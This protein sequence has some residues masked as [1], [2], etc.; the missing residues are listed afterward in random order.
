M[1]NIQVPVLE[2]V[3]AIPTPGEGI[4]VRTCMDVEFMCRQIRDHKIAMVERD[5]IEKARDQL[6]AILDNERGQQ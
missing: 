2:D 4:I 5:L 6:S 3:G 1:I